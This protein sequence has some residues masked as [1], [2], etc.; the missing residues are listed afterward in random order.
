MEWFK[1]SLPASMTQENQKC[2]MNIPVTSI[3]GK[4]TFSEIILS[5]GKTIIRFE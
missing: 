1:L 3:T 5:P 4:K 2:T